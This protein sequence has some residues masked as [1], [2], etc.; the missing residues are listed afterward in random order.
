MYIFEMIFR[1]VVVAAKQTWAIPRTITLAIRQR[2][3]RF[4]HQQFEM[5]RLDRIRNPSKYA[6]R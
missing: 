2:Q 3:E 6:G 1:T 4:A 5:E